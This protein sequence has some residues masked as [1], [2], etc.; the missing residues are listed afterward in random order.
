MLSQKYGEIRSLDQEK[1]FEASPIV[2]QSSR[3]GVAAIALKGQL[4]LN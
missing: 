3:K 2:D 4:L 1:H